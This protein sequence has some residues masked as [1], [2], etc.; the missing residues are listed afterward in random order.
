MGWKKEYRKK[1]TDA[2]QALNLVQSGNRVAIGHAC[3]EPTH[4]VDTMV[5]KAEQYEDVE[6]VHMVPMGKA[7]YTLPEMKTHFRHNALFV[8]GTA[9]KAVAEGSGDYTPCFFYRIPELFTN[10]SLPVDVALVQAAPPDEEGNL[11]LG[12][13]IDYSLPA[14]RAAKKSNCSDK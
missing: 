4:L 13:S 12:I 6:I 5:S 7:E 9:R 1:L 10:G 2:D 14:A 3:A 11:S 8:G